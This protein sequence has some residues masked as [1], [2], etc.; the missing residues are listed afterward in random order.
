MLSGLNSS[1][2]SYLSLQGQ[3][4]AAT[5]NAAAGKSS[6]PT[7]SSAAMQRAA[8]TAKTSTAVHNLDTS[9]KKLAT[10]LRAAMDKA[11]V[12]L[13]GAIEFSVKSD[14][15]V[16]IKGS[17]ADK[18]A[19]QAFLKADTSQ[20][21][22]ANRIATQARDALKL[23]TSIQQ[24]AAISQAAKLAKTSGGVM[25]LYTSLMQQTAATSVVFSVSAASSSLTYP[26]S[27]ATNA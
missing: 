23:S 2:L 27:L 10:E 11:G 20:P 13:T 21:G 22:F 1:L 26:G 9:Q 16:D 5:S 6:T 7:I 15:S 18:A 24:S 17:D 12:H 8:G 14:G 3:D 19:T 4:S 25:S